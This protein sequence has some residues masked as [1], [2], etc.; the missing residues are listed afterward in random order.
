[1]AKVTLDLVFLD[2]STEYL[3]NISSGD[4]E[5]GGFC[6]ESYWTFGGEYQSD[7]C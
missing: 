6:G 3:F 4:Q 1:M 5:S 2:C 7:T